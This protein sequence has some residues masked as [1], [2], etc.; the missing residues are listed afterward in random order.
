MPYF[1]NII[2]SL[3]GFCKCLAEYTV[4]N[5][6]TLLGLAYLIGVVEPCCQIV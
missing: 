6:V 3:A 2:C 1:G 5:L 4:H